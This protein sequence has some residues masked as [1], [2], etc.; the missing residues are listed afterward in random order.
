MSEERILTEWWERCIYIYIS[1]SLCGCVCVCV[2]RLL[3]M[4]ICIPLRCFFFQERGVYHSVAVDPF[5]LL[6]VMLFTIRW[7]RMRLIN[8][9]YLLEAAWRLLGL[10]LYKVLFGWMHIREFREMLL[11]VGRRWNLFMKIREFWAIIVGIIGW[12]MLRI[13]RLKV[14]SWL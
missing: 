13:M 10:R 3:Y 9:S 1:M 12:W 2:E 14:W 4:Y 11:L 7:G 8:G 6:L 5:S